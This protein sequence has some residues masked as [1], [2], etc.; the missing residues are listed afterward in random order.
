MGVLRMFPGLYAARRIDKASFVI[1][2]Q[3]AR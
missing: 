1:H 3:L 2:K